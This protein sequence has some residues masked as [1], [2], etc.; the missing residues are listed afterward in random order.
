MPHY[1]V[2][3]AKAKLSELIDRAEKGESVTI[4]RHGKPVVEMRPAAAP[5]RRMTS[6][7]LDRLA[8]GRRARKAKGSPVAQM[9]KWRDE[10]SL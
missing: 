4:T 3:E 6:A 7:D 10:G 8:Q 1:S 9:L 5:P 2:A